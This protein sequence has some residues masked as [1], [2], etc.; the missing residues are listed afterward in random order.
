MNFLIIFESTFFPYK[1]A[2]EY[3]IKYMY[4]LGEII[5]KKPI[6]LLKFL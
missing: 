4:K 6:Y 1:Q 2:R 3:A 5:R